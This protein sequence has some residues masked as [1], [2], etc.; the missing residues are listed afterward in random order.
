MEI[1]KFIEVF[2]DLFDD[3]DVNELKPETKFK[4][5]DEWSSIMALSVIAMIDEEYGVTIGGE[6]IHKSSTIED[7]YHL[8][9]S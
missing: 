4:E 9:N 2:A 6:H 7:L 8:I 3:T 5:L 1:Q